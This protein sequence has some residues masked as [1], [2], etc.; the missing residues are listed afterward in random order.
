MIGLGSDKN[1]KSKSEF[2]KVLI[3]Q[4]LQTS[5]ILVNM[6]RLRSSDNGINSVPRRDKKSNRLQI[7]PYIHSFHNPFGRT[8]FGVAWLWEE[9]EAKPCTPDQLG[10]PEI[11]VFKCGKSVASK[12]V[13]PAGWQIISPAPKSWQQKKMC[14]KKKTFGQFWSDRFKTNRTWTQ[15]NWLA[16]YSFQNDE[17]KIGRVSSLWYRRFYRKFSKWG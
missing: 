2:W 7:N 16:F 3:I 14:H 5:W 17:T 13:T 12:I 10:N 15:P 1:Y 9:V 8:Q 11:F 6:T 4:T